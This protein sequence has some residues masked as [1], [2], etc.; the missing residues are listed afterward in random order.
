MCV[1]YVVQIRLSLLWL[2]LCLI[3]ESCKVHLESETAGKHDAR[4]QTAARQDTRHS[5]VF[6]IH[7][8]RKNNMKANVLRTGSHCVFI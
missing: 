2:S 3:A 8:V 1:L 5:T 4:K 6:V 7:S